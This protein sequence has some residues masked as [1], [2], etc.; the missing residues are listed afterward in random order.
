VGLGQTD[1]EIGELK[2]L[3]H[4]RRRYWSVHLRSCTAELPSLHA[5]IE[6]ERFHLKERHGKATKT[7]EQYILV[8]C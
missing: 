6:N 1:A 2:Q 3:N 7:A 4:R 8:E 5:V